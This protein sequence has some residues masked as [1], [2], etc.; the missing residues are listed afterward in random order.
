MCP[1]SLH[2]SKNFPAGLS[3]IIALV[4]AIQSI[5]APIRRQENKPG[6]KFYNDRARKNFKWRKQHHQDRPADPSHHDRQGIADTARN[7]GE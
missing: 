1:P 7:A 5:S 2:M 6:N 4:P 3:S